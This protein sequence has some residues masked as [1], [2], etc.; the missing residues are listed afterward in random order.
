MEAAAL[1]VVVVI[2][3]LVVVLCKAAQSTQDTG[4]QKG[5]IRCPTCGSPADVVGE[6]WECTWCGDSGRLQ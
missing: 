1:V 5:S 2:V 3:I 4:R 6:W